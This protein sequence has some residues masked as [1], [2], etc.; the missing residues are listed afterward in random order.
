ML[1]RFIGNKKQILEPLLE[2]IR[3]LAVP[4]SMVCDIF[5]GTLAVS[6]ALKNSGFRVASND[7]NAFS[8]AYGRAYLTNGGIPALNLDE[9]IGKQARSRGHATV[10]SPFGL[11]SATYQ[12]FMA[13]LAFLSTT[14]VSRLPAK[15]RRSDILDTYS[16]GG[17][18]SHYRSVR[19]TEGSRRFF[20]SENAARIDIVLNWLRLWRSKKCLSDEA[21]YL[22]LCCLLDAVERVSNIQGTYHDFPRNWYDPRALRPIVLTGPKSELL[23]GPSDGH[24]L[25]MRRD[26]LDFIEEVPEHDLLYVDPPYNFRQ[27]TSYY[28]L[29]NLISRYCELQDLDDH[30]ANV[31][32]VRGQ[33]MTDD[34]DSSFSRRTSFVE[35]LRTLLAKSRSRIV[36]LS[37]FNGR[38]HWAEP[39]DSEGLGLGH[40]T[41]LFTSDLFRPGSLTV[42]PLERRNYQSY[43]G[44]RAEA[45]GEM[46]LIAERSS[47]LPRPMPARKVAAIG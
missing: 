45:V 2:Q 29:P 7:I 14:T 32:F 1:N 20:S 44:Y 26:S 35:S 10:P 18:N 21:Y 6:L 41:D 27:Y 13:L 5:S 17:S 34:F 37:Y 28:F 11:Q 38:N 22:L 12:E 47:S 43:V 46:L 30:F 24:L 9:L 25:G 19:G 8:Y 23:E 3:A 4:G 39:R 42:V 15:Y 16:E 31:Q 40:L 36:I 33:N